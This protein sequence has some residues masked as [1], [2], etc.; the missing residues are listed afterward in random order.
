V[1]KPSA[2]SA[3]LKVTFHTDYW[4]NPSEF[5]WF[6]VKLPHKY[7]IIIKRH[8]L[9]VPCDEPAMGQCYNVQQYSAKH[10]PCSLTMILDLSKLQ[11]PYIETLL[12]Q[13]HGISI[14]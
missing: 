11:S 9:Y 6:A 8:V 10:E 7:G 5:F 3:S 13:S 12:F 1:Y 4:K 2:L 14:P